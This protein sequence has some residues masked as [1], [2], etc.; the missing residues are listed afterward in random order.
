MEDINIRHFKMINGDD[1][2]AFIQHNNDNTYMVETP[3]LVEF[4][5]MGGFSSH[6]GSRSQ[7]REHTNW[8]RAR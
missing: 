7:I 6:H 2:L 8:T 4:N 5:M 3:V 1:V